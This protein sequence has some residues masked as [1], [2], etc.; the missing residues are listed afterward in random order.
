MS[1]D[2]LDLIDGAIEACETSADA[3]RWSADPAAVPAA[4]SPSRLPPWPLPEWQ[5]EAI[6]ARLFDIPPELLR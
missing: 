4:E 6:V 3:M 2:I 1:G 5:R